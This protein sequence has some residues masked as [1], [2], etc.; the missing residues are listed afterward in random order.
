MQASVQEFYKKGYEASNMN[1][2]AENANVS[3]A[4]VYKHFKSKKDLFFALMMILSDEISKHC[5]PITHSSLEIKA[6]SVNRCTLQWLNRCTQCVYVA[7]RSGSATSWID[8]IER[9]S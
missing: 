8:G 6:R 4:T 7:K 1:V 3:K 9:E 2:I 5:F